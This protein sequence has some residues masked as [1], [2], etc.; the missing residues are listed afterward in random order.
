MDG[1]PRRPDASRPRKR[2]STA[3]DSWAGSSTATTASRTNAAA[4]TNGARASG[5]ASPAP[6]SRPSS[7]ASVHVPLG[8]RARTEAPSKPKTT[9]VIDIT[10][11]DDEEGDKAAPGDATTAAPKASLSAAEVVAAV[12]ASGTANADGSTASR[13]AA[14]ANCASALATSLV[15]QAGD[16][17][18]LLALFI[19]LANSTPSSTRHHAQW[20]HVAGQYLG[21]ANPRVR[22]AACTA[23]LRLHEAR[24][25]TNTLDAA[26]YSHVATSAIVDKDALVRKAAIPLLRA[27][28]QTYPSE[29]SPLDPPSRSAGPANQ[30]NTLVADAFCRICDRVINDTSV[31]IRRAAAL[32]LGEFPLVPKDLLLQTLSKKALTRNDGRNAQDSQLADAWQR[33][34]GAF[35]HA[36]EDEF[37][38]VRHAALDAIAK[39][40]TQH[41]EFTAEAVD[42][43]VDMSNDEVQDIR[44]RA[45]DVL[46]TMSS[47][48]PI[49]LSRTDIEDFSDLFHDPT[50]V[51][52]HRLYQFLGTV[53]YDSCEAL[54]VVIAKLRQNLNDVPGDIQ[55]LMRAFKDVAVVNGDLV[56]QDAHMILKLDPRFLR[57]EFRVDEVQQV[58]PLVLVYNAARTRPMLLRTLPKFMLRMTAF[59]N[60][61]Y[62]GCFTPVRGRPARADASSQL[63]MDALTKFLDSVT[64]QTTLAKL[65]EANALGSEPNPPPHVAFLHDLLHLHLDAATASAGDFWPITQIRDRATRVATQYTATTSAGTAIDI[66]SAL[67]PLRALVS[68]TGT[69]AAVPTPLDLRRAAVATTRALHL[70]DITHVVKSTVHIAVIHPARAGAAHDAVRAAPLLPLEIVLEL[71]VNVPSKANAVVVR[72]RFPDR[73]D[74]YVPAAPR[75]G[76]GD[77]PWRTAV[78]VAPRAWRDPGCVRLAAG[79]MVQEEGV[80]GRFVPGSEEVEVWVAFTA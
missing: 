46:T 4:P 77:V 41:R 12:L 2:T 70:L 42:F 43:L 58:A 33:S 23:L 56:A 9:V 6:S 61:A 20:H 32:E 66:S 53:R 62:P 10:S 27:F 13:N 3:D 21:H 16:D 1:A 75:E 15:L 18:A 60:R 80:G 14:G 11:S 26:L 38:E 79:W 44:N 52:R 37:Q 29:P 28:A 74:E 57:K 71:A 50:P 69:S 35:V 39:L 73:S 5:S 25:T 8:K 51:I 64:E 34:A 63:V 7:A 54:K 78:R 40:G 17:Q 47:T 31:D 49:T 68:A 19:S 59:L 22:E 36:T 48:A 76:S 55:E 65:V 30:S 67:T 45:I 24:G 72:A